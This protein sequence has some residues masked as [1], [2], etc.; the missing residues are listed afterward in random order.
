MHR[1]REPFSAGASFRD[2]QLTRRCGDGVTLRLAAFT[3]PRRLGV[4]VQ[5]P[6]PLPP[7]RFLR[8]IGVPMEFVKNTMR[9]WRDDDRRRDEKD[10]P[11]IERER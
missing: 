6:L 11:R 9:D 4:T 1:W 2:V 7:S 5:I 8:V 3:E 10:Q